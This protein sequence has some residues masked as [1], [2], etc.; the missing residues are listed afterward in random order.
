M[1][2][3]P[4]RAFTYDTLIIRT[5]QGQSGTWYAA[6]IKWNNMESDFI[7][8]GTTEMLAVIDLCNQEQEQI[9]HFIERLADDE[10]L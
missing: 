3:E 2:Q 1:I 4:I 8:T 9:D 6:F 5:F 7:G 10:P